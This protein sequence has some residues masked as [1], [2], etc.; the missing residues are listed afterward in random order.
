MVN[1]VILSLLVA[2]SA[3][4]IDGDLISLKRDPKGKPFSPP[5]NGTFSKQ[6]GDLTR[7]LGL[8]FNDSNLQLK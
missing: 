1:L 7:S 8:L 6:K 3:T 2:F 5:K 4:N